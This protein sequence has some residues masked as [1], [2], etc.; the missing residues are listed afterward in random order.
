MRYYIWASEHLPYDIRVANYFPTTW[1]IYLKKKSSP[2]PKNPCLFPSLKRVFLSFWNSI[3]THMPFIHKI[4]K[5]RF[6]ETFSEKPT[7]Y[8][9]LEDGV[10]ELAAI[11]WGRTEEIP[12]LISISA[13]IIKN[14]LLLS[15]YII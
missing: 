14:D 3:P 10:I 2:P 8:F 12:L 1:I 6:Y 11:L 7:I 5:Q 9:S 15:H 13:V 4:L